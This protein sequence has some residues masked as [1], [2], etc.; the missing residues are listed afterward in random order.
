MEWEDEQLK[1]TRTV[2][3]ASTSAAQDVDVNESAEERELLDRNFGTDLT[4]PMLEEILHRYDDEMKYRISMDRGQRAT[5]AVIPVAKETSYRAGDITIKPFGLIDRDET[6]LSLLEWREAM[7]KDFAKRDLNRISWEEKRRILDTRKMFTMEFKVGKPEHWSIC[8]EAGRPYNDFNAA[9]LEVVRGEVIPGHLRRITYHEF[10]ELGKRIHTAQAVSKLSDRELPGWS[11]IMAAGR[12]HECDYC[13][14][15]PHLSRC[16][17]SKE[18]IEQREH[19]A[20]HAETRPLTQAGMVDAIDNVAQI[21]KKT[22]TVC[23]CMLCNKDIL[24]RCECRGALGLAPVEGVP[25]YRT[26][27]LDAKQKRKRDA[28][29]ECI[30]LL[31]TFRLLQGTGRTL[32]IN[33]PKAPIQ[34]QILDPEEPRRYSPVQTSR[35]PALLPEEGTSAPVRSPFKYGARKSVEP[36]SQGSTSKISPSRETPRKKQRSTEPPS[37]SSASQTPEPSVVTAQQVLRHGSERR[38]VEFDRLRGIH[39]GRIV[40]Q[41]VGMG[42]FNKEDVKYHEGPPPTGYRWITEAEWC[43]ITNRYKAKGEFIPMDK[44]INPTQEEIRALPRIPEHLQRFYPR[45]EPALAVHTDLRSGRQGKPYFSKGPLWHGS[46]WLNE[47][48]VAEYERTQRVAN[49][50]ERE[51]PRTMEG[52]QLASSAEREPAPAVQQVAPPQEIPSPQMEQEGEQSSD[53]AERLRQEAQ[54]DWEMENMDQKD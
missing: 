11:Q 22:D 18:N 44:M 28:L 6:R 47:Q 49:K 23:R 42:L 9:H 4:L 3:L 29:A 40:R 1:M 45:D 54:H 15:T 2:R 52:A 12:I 25:E 20:A 19:A 30:Q 48:E 27:T 10:V 36:M 24:E 31:R 7:E 35:R 21:C 53:E 43:W 5:M 37:D 50:A 32:M 26:L 51:H 33:G 38:V 14:H 8:V 17:F 13:R 39:H 34:L 46:R 16:R 41:D